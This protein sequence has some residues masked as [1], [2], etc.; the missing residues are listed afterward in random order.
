M[1]RLIFSSVFILVLW[2]GAHGQSL[3]GTTGWLNI[4]TAEMQEDGTFY[5]GGSYVSSSYIESYGG[6]KYNGL[7]YY[8]NVTFLP[9]LEIGFGNTSLLNYT[10]SNN[11]VDRNFSLRVRPLRERKYIPAIVIGAHDIYTS[12]DPELGNQYFSSLYIVLTKH[13]DVRSSS[14]GITLGYGFPVFKN[15]QFEGVFGGISFSPGFYRALKIIAEY[16]GESYNLGATAVFFK[17]LYVNATVQDLKYFSGGLAYKVFLIN[18]YKKKRK[19]A[20]K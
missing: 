12:V 18:K 2:G 16:D 19:Q 3:L 17:H 1:K 7:I 4:P 9:F 20:A 8:L 15:N 13:I 14:F 10:L 6:G 11:T 5:L